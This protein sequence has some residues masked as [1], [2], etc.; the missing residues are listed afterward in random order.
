MGKQT[1]IEANRET[2]SKRSKE[3]GGRVGWGAAGISVNAVIRR[4]KNSVGSKD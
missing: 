2:E 4:R 3:S 1:N